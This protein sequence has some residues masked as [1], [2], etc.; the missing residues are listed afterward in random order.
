LRGRSSV[1]AD[2]SAD[3]FINGTIGLLNNRYVVIKGDRVTHNYEWHFGKPLGLGR[4]FQK[5]GEACGADCCGRE[6]SLFELNG[7]LDTPERAAPSVAGA[8][9]RPIAGRNN[10]VHHCLF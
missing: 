5:S 7:T 9:D 8:Q 4:G 2:E 3:D 1:I 6:V 10:V